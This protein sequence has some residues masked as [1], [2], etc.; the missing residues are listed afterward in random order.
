MQ[1]VQS[2]QSSPGH[3]V[4]FL[5]TYIVLIVLASLYFV[6]SRLLLVSLE[7]VLSI[8]Y[9]NQG[10]HIHMQKWKE[11][12]IEKSGDGRNKPKCTL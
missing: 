11:R 2:M 8:F 10:T 4:F 5:K 9:S 7:F 3:Q 6:P 1:G 12:K